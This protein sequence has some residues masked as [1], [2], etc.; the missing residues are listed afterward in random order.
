MPLPNPFQ[1]CQTCPMLCASGHSFCSTRSL[2]LLALGLAAV[3]SSPGSS[4]LRVTS[5]ATRPASSASRNANLPGPCVSSSYARAR[6]T[7][8]QR[9]CTI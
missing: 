5:S 2:A 8:A 3:S 7:C 6:V 1:P 9:Q 4:G